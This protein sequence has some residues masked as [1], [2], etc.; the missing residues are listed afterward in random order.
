MT[1]GNTGSGWRQEP[2]RLSKQLQKTQ[3]PQIKKLNQS[4]GSILVK[5][6][7]ATPLKID[8]E[9]LESEAANLDPIL[10]DLNREI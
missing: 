10:A 7:L 9:M 1:F 2:F 4:S 5:K 8:R 3:T 6:R